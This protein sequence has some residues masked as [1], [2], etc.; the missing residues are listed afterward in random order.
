MVSSLWRQ[1]GPAAAASWDSAEWAR[2]LAAVQKT[3][4][5]LDAAWCLISSLRLPG[6]I[7]WNTIR[8]RLDLHKQLE[9]LQRI[10]PGRSAQVE[11]GG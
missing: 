1:I 8:T 4:E 2:R 9:R 10:M 7:G 5:T 11:V 3:R 6:N